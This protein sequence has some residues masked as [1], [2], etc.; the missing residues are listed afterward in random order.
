MR[1]NGVIEVRTV[2]IW[3][4][5]NCNICNSLEDVKELNMGGVIVAMCKKCRKETY[6]V[7]YEEIWN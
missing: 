3:N 6:D 2:E 5:R 4:I 7:L 1:P